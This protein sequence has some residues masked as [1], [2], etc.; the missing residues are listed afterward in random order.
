MVKNGEC[1]R[2]SFNIFVKQVLMVPCIVMVALF[3][4]ITIIVADYDLSS[5]ALLITGNL[6]GYALIFAIIVITTIIKHYRINHQ[7]NH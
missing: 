1:L 4:L 3:D 7:Q 5:A 6:I 2:E